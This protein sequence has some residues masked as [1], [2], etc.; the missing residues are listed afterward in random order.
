MNNTS[1]QRKLNI[2]VVICILAV[3]AG[4]AM[5][6]IILRMEQRNA[7]VLENVNKHLELSLTSAPAEKDRL[8]GMSIELL[9]RYRDS[10]RQ[11]SRRLTAVVVGSVAIVVLVMILTVLF[12]RRTFIR[13]VRSVHELIRSIIRG[14]LDARLSLGNRDEIGRTAELVNELGNTLKGILGETIGTADAI[15]IFVEKLN[16]SSEIMQQSTETTRTKTG[17]IVTTSSE[18]AAGMETVAKAAEQAST[19]VSNIS[20]SVEAFSSSMNTMAT[21]AEQASDN[22]SDI[23]TNVNAISTQIAGISTSVEGLS[24]S[25]NHINKNTSDAMKYS[26]QTT[27][28][29]EKTLESMND[30]VAVTQEISKILKLVNG[31][32]SQ[33]NMLALN[34]TIEAA[35]AGEA[36]KG[37]AVVAGEIKELARQTAD[38]NGEIASQIK[39]VQEYV[40]KS[41]NQVQNI[42]NVFNTVSE[43]NQGISSLVEEQTR[44]SADLV[45]AIDSV[46]N[47]ARDSA[48][49]IEEAAD[50][51]REIT[52]STTMASRGSAETAHSA[53]EASAGVKEIARSSIATANG[54]KEINRHIQSINDAINDVSEIIN[55]NRKNLVDFSG[56]TEALERSVSLFTENSSTLFFW[57]DQLS[58]KNEMI[59]AQHR[60][61]VNTMNMLYRNLKE[62]AAPAV[63]TENLDTLFGIA[64]TH[65]DQEQRLFEAT[66]YPDTESHIERHRSI[67]T[68]LQEYRGKVQEDPADIA[69]E[70][71]FFL[72]GWLLEHMLTVDRAYIPYCSDAE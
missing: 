34:A 57:S 47:A 40:F 10:V 69:E 44:N 23:S 71:S 67:M 49:S 55:S 41:Q 64:R 56:M 52:R 43:L 42:S 2:A 19:N 68:R 35:S 72:K 33:T 37:F 59:D 30:L 4:G 17:I 29:V 53:S 15:K 6:L 16:S 65:F 62:K 50:G 11:S 8:S 24:E 54:L 63:L 31:I 28:G 61:I 27:S 45:S 48:R 32:A 1:I 36:G 18:L 3:L 14:N 26:E 7:V 60:E 22:M 13:P 20:N 12:F 51:I 66:D 70:I 5:A 46:S 58:V 39:R 9:N 21:A 25:L 38:A